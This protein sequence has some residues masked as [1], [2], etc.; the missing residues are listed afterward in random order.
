MLWRF[1]VGTDAAGSGQ[2]LVCGKHC[3]AKQGKHCLAKQGIPS[4]AI[5]LRFQL[6]QLLKKEGL[7]VVWVRSFVCCLD[8][9]GLF[10]CVAGYLFWCQEETAWCLLMPLAHH[11]SANPP[12]TT[13]ANCRP[14]HMLRCLIFLEH[15]GSAIQSIL[16]HPSKLQTPTPHDP[17]LQVHAHLK[18]KPH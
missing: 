12:T 18:L 5:P 4:P 13:P 3:V 16:H 10:F 15:N 7:A 1:R 17:Q 11:G 2:W 8:C 14:S 6:L 9:R